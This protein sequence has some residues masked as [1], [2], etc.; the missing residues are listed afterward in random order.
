MS[1][2]VFVVAYEG[3]DGG[4]NVL[5]YAISRARKDNA[6]LMLVH[7]LEWS[8]YQFL[9]PEELEERHA[10]RSQ[11]IKR[12]QEVIIEPALEKCRAAGIEADASLTYGSVVPL[13]AKAATDCAASMI[14][15]GRSGSNTIGA[16]IFGSVPL[17]LA[18]VASV[19]TVIVP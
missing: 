5:D 17:G 10:R 19:P 13:V 9:T 15:V 7:V 16:R 11:E 3:E 4:S 14:F 12:A 1:H 8:P 2:E 6:S 18:Q